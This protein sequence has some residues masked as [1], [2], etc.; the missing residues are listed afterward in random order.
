VRCLSGVFARPARVLANI[1]RF[2]NLETLDLSG[3]SLAGHGAELGRALSRGPPSLWRV[4]IAK[5]YLGLEG[6]RDMCRA[7]MASPSLAPLVGLDLSDNDIGREGAEEVAEIFL[8]CP[9]L[10]YLQELSLAGSNIGLKGAAYVGANAMQEGG[11]PGAGCDHAVQGAWLTDGPDAALREVRILSFARNGLFG[12][13]AMK[14][15]R[16]AWKAGACPDLESLDLSDFCIVSGDDKELAA[17]LRRVVPSAPHDE[18]KEV[19]FNVPAAPSGLPSTCGTFSWRRLW[20]KD[21]GRYPIDARGHAGAGPSDARPVAQPLPGAIGDGRGGG[22]ATWATRPRPPIAELTG[23]NVGPEGAAELLVTLTM[24]VCH[25]LE[26]LRVGENMVGLADGTALVRALVHIPGLTVLDLAGARRHPDRGRRGHGPDRA[27]GRAA[28]FRSLP[29]VMGSQPAAGGG[30]WA[31]Q[32]KDVSLG[33]SPVQTLGATQ[34][35]VWLD[36]LSNVLDAA[37]MLCYLCRWGMWTGCGSPPSAPT[38]RATLS[39]SSPSPGW[40]VLR[41][42]VC[43]IYGAYATHYTMSLDLVCN[44]FTPFLLKEVGTVWSLLSLLGFWVFMCESSVIM[45]GYAALHMPAFAVLVGLGSNSFASLKA[46]NDVG[47]GH[48][49]GGKIPQGITPG[50]VGDSW[51]LTEPH[52]VS[53]AGDAL[54]WGQVA[55]LTKASLLVVGTLEIFTGVF[56]LVNIICIFLLRRLVIR[57]VIPVPLPHAP[58]AEAV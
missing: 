28:A 5:N 22:H 9:A 6:V 31:D 27:G 7:L 53:D 11:E 57:A 17:V 15:L 19:W 10:H 38:W 44:V 34:G 41:D 39:A 25:D 12:V 14:K 51:I 32:T 20:W 47:Q 29:C 45:A 3:S 40:P 18:T 54:W 37:P 33:G 4:S 8:H 24:G 56:Q 52:H 58:P 30:R 13:E 46:V 26:V 2:P 23:C 43:F 21:P 50:E 36:Q 49:R 42:L 55:S 16:P 1:H 35:A 48:D